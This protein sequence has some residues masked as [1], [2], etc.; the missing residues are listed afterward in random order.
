[1]GARQSSHYFTSGFN[2]ILTHLALC[3]THHISIHGKFEFALFQNPFL[4]PRIDE[5]RRNYISREIISTGR[6]FHEPIFISMKWNVL[7]FRTLSTFLEYISR[8]TFCWAVSP[9]FHHSC[10][11]ECKLTY[12]LIGTVI[13]TIVS[14]FIKTWN[15]YS[16]LSMEFI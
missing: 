12:P 15:A 6:N 2:R 16:D 11:N 4:I 1:M 9:E 5:F 14:A 7:N 8:S 13:V 10:Q 3:R